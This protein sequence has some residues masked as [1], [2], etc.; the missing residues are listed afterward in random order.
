MM[1]ITTRKLAI[2]VCAL[3]GLCAIDASAQSRGVYWRLDT[4]YARAA[5]A[6][7]KDKDPGGP[8]G[9]FI[10]GGAISFASACNIPPGELNDIG[11]GWI[12]GVGVGYRFTP[13]LRADATFSY[14]NG[15]KLDDTDQ[16][17][18][19]YSARITSYNVMVNG[20]V[21]F[22]LSR[23]KAV[24]PYV[25]AGVGYASNKID[26][27]TN[28]NLPPLPPGVSTLPGGTSNGVAWQ[29]SFGV[30]IKVTRKVTLD[31]G[32]RYLDSGKIETN[33]G[34]VT[35]AFA[36]PY[37]GATGNLRTHELQVGVRF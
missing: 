24:V 5:D 16:A 28:D 12:A 13:R 36:Q 37:P 35:G 26:D 10:C 18:S 20:Y 8:S 22:P 34:N 31:V 14:R 6:N 7:L 3:T 33:S 32:Y 4:G 19:S 29:V 30:S 15:F 17:P 25:G 9:N 2:V 1:M 21:D 27:I 11:G 23:M